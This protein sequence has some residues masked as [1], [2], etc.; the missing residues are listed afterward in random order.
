[1][2]STFT[3]GQEE[4][5]L[6][7][8]QILKAICTFSFLNLKKIEIHFGGVKPHSSNRQLALRAWEHDAKALRRFSH[9]L[10][11]DASDS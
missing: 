6:C 10:A 7:C 11:A 5:E 3:S 8:I 2:F 9:P 1:M 4:Q